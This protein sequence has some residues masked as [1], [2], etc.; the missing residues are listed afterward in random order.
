MELVFTVGSPN[1]TPDKKNYLID[2]D[3][4]IC[5]D[6]P[7]EKPELMPGAYEIP[8]AREAVVAL[9]EQGHTITF[10]TSRTEAH[11]DATVAW[12]ADHGFVY[13]GLMM[14]KP[15]G[16]NY[17]WIDDKSVTGVRVLDEQF[18]VRGEHKMA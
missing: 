4:T 15:R 18:W 9:Y 10:F 16:G 2:I 1:L 7:N 6:V 5:E 17:V 8:G 12:L 11:R 13:H 14:G 3:G